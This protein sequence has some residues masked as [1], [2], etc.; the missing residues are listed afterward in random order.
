MVRLRFLR[1]PGAWLWL[2]LAVGAAL[3]I[4]LV[5]W[6]EGTFDVAIKNHH[7]HQILERGLIGWYQVLEIAN[8]PPLMGR[9]FAALTSLAESTGVPFRILIRAPFALLDL[10]TALLLWRLMSASP[11]RW[12]LLAA[13]WLHPLSILFSAY[14]GNTDSAVAFFALLA[15]LL[16]SRRSA[17]GAGVALGVGL[18]VKLPVL[19]AAPVLLSAFPDWQSRTRFAATSGLVA[20][21]G[22]L[23]TLAQE[24]L[25]L[26]SRIVGYGGTPV[27]LPSGT[28][29][30]G[31][32]N[33]VGLGGTAVARALASA[34]VFVVWIPIL[35]W[36]WLRRGAFAPREL[37]VSVA[38]SYFILYG[39]T[40]YWAWQYLAWV[41]PFALCLGPRFAIATAV[42]LGGYVWGAYAH[43]TGSWLLAGRWNFVSHAPWP[44]VLEILRDAS[45]VFCFA[46]A[47]LL[48]GQAALRESRWRRATA[49]EAP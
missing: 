3:R 22:Y 40:S 27:E 21:V 9:L 49:G 48:I 15:T 24:P 7:G 19:V 29:V 14:H 10:G 11:W 47:A 31:L 25:L 43:M 2:A 17:V 34:N 1:A 36:A 35:A 16:A 46:T 13:C 20:V 44:L 39:L 5:G 4:Y 33:A 6:T 8:H 38:G 26:V 41:V 37:A 30:W 28:V 45:V 32:A 12:V 23:P 42:I 18:W